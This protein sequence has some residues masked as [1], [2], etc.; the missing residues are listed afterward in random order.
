LHPIQNVLALQGRLLCLL[1][2][3]GLCQCLVRRLKILLQLVI[4]LQQRDELM[5]GVL[6]LPQGRD[7]PSHF[8]RI[9][10]GYQIRSDNNGVPIQ[11]RVG[12]LLQDKDQTSGIGSN[13]VFRHIQT[14]HD[15]DA[16]EVDGDLFQGVSFGRFGGQADGVFSGVTVSHPVFTLGGHDSDFCQSH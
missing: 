5:P 16:F 3:R 2:G 11:R 12:L 10:L 4:F 15:G 7:G 8:F 14:V 6:V 9:D 1:C 13:L